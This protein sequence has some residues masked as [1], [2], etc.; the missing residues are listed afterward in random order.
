MHRYLYSFIIGFLSYF[1]IAVLILYFFI[2]NNYADEN[3]KIKDMNKVCFS[4]IEPEHKHKIEKKTKQ[5]P[6]KSKHKPRL[7]HTPKEIEKKS[8]PIV[9]EP[10]P[11][12]KQINK[13]P[14]NKIFKPVST[15]VQTEK[16]IENKIVK[17]IYIKKKISN[18]KLTSNTTE[19][20]N[21][22]TEAKKQ[23]FIADLIKRINRNKSY[24]RV[25]RRR[26]IQG[27]IEMKFIIQMDGRV[28]DIQVISGK[29]IFKKSAIKAIKSSFPIN[30]DAK[31]FSFPKNFKI[32]INYILK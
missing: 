32:K 6:V 7:E 16:A 14:D 9:V 10:K 30:I 12:P 17:K 4:I 18:K 8:K 19:I 29:N 3:I 11:I 27:T 23:N 26:S 22:I 28:K 1:F 13:K 24:P 31:L 25:A 2:E 21:N 20:T 15:L 5:K